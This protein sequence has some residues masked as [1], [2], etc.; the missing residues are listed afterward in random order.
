[1]N[2]HSDEYRRKSVCWYQLMSIIN[3]TKCLIKLWTACIIKLV[4]WNRNESNLYDLDLWVDSTSSQFFW[5]FAIQL[6]MHGSSWCLNWQDKYVSSD[7]KD[8]W[9]RKFVID[10]SNVLLCV[11]QGFVVVPSLIE[12]PVVYYLLLSAHACFEFRYGP[13]NVFN[14]KIPLI[15]PI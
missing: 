13:K 9:S 15:F 6:K 3:I 10:W 4:D 12:L 7:P 5:I 11:L 2:N 8:W 14:D 1:M